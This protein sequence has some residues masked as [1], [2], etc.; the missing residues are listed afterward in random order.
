MAA[1][2]ISARTMHNAVRR[3]VMDRAW[4]WRERTLPLERAAIET[5]ERGTPVSAAAQARMRDSH[6]C[7]YALEVL[8][9]RIERSRPRDFT[10]GE[11]VRTFA[12]DS[13][14]AD[15]PRIRA[16]D[17]MTASAIAAEWAAI[18][19]HVASLTTDGIHAVGHVPTRF[20]LPERQ[21]ARVWRRLAEVW[22]ARPGNHYWYPLLNACPPGVIAF[23]AD[24]FDVDVGARAV[25]ELLRRH[26]VSRVWLMN[27]FQEHANYELSPLLC[28]FGGRV[29]E[30]Y[31]TSPQLDW[32][33]Y[34]SH[35]SS[36]T[37]AGR[38]LVEAVQQIWPAWRDH[39][40][41]HWDYARPPANARWQAHRRKAAIWLGQGR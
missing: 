16:H 7:A 34:V 8:L 39:L 36:V 23:Q 25:Q 12:L 24:W 5:R 21:R 3:S 30:A 26:G 33:V 38:W 20:V 18:R 15:E 27:E 4:R 35:E 19:D 37:V 11:A 14:A 2:D 31:W 32:L 22:D 10:S 6:M 41:E 28:H 40:Y 29:G 13:T 17:A 9:E 1:S